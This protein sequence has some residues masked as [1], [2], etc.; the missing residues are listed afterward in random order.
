MGADLRSISITR[1]VVAH[2]RDTIA[3]ADRVLMLRDGIRHLG[4]GAEY[5]LRAGRHGTMQAV[6]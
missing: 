3:A 5:R 6:K 2:R 4:S 1:I